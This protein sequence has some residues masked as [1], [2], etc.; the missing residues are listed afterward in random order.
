MLGL[1]EEED[2]VIQTLM[3]IK[4]VDCDFLTLGQYLPPSLNHYSLKEYVHPDKFNYFESYARKIGFRG[5]K[6]APYVRSSYLAHSFFK[7]EG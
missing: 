6:S 1:G 2:Q 7:D 5:V 3:D 4:R